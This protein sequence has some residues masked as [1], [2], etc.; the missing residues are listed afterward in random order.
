MTLLGHYSN[1]N[2]MMHFSPQ[3]FSIR[4]LLAMVGGVL[5]SLGYIHV[6]LF[7]G[8]WVAFIPLLIAIKHMSY[9]NSYLLG[10][11]FGMVL[12]LC[13]TTWIVDFLTLFKNYRGL[14][15]FSWSL[16]YWVYCAQLPALMV[17]CYQWLKRNTLV[18]EFILFPISV[19]LF[20]SSFPMLFSAQLGESQS[21]FLVAIQAVEF[22]G[23]YSL[24]AII[25]LV[26]V[27]LFKILFDRGL[28]LKGISVAMT[29][30][31]LV[32]WF[33]YGVYALQTWDQTI[34][35]WR[36][37][38]IGLVQP[39]ET[40]SLKKAEVYPGY[41]RAYPVEMDMTERLRSQGAELVLW[42]E[43]RYKGYID[44]PHVENAFKREVAQLDVDLIFQDMEKQE[45]SKEKS[46][47]YNLAVMLNNEGEEVGRYR[48][49]K[50]VAFGEYVPLVSD[51]P[52][53]RQWVEAFFGNF[54]NEIGKGDGP[55]IFKSGQMNIVPLVCYETMFAEFVANAVPKQPQGSI[56]VG[57]S[58]NGWFGDSVQPYQHIYAA[59]LRAVE[60]RLPMI[61]VLNN[62]P[63]VVVM[64][65]GRF[66]FVSDYHQAGGY[67]VDMPFDENSGGSFFSRFPN[68]FLYAVYGLVMAIVLVSRLKG[69][70][71]NSELINHGFCRNDRVATVALL[72]A[73][74][75]IVISIYPK[76]EAFKVTD[77]SQVWKQPSDSYEQYPKSIQP[78]AWRVDF[79]RIEK[80]LAQA[81]LMDDGALALTTETA[82]FLERLTLQYPNKPTEETR[83]RIQFLIAKTL[84]A[85]ASEQVMDLSH[86][87]S[88]FHAANTLMLKE[89]LDKPLTSAD[90]AEQRFMKSVRLK[91]QY[92][93]REVTEKLY[94]AQHDMALKMFALQREMS[95]NK[96][97]KND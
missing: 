82:Q 46:K 60:N 57:L 67:L 52:F 13:A 28:A 41:G 48:K 15:N 8:A 16:L 50:R 5:L 18:S 7:W 77:Q 78:N 25:A 27:V 74:S 70:R 64:P 44:I 6:D 79:E 68:L 80:I 66:L 31:I 97:S 22:F 58:S 96:L 81:P 43:A 2:K 14:T 75:L 42:P 17:L 62:G 47:R 92:L 34:S 9:R 90:D 69:V 45:E 53:L 21:G 24:D 30:A 73:V 11:A 32:A 55:V 12:F 26:N 91:E 61:H 37:V 10:F 33:G 94:S 65:N 1:K 71:Q 19:V 39:N 29:A 4:L 3:W 51:I 38:R 72:F 63:S 40:P 49:M 35:Q 84:P 85:Q 23:V 59:S 83:K 89:L 87:Y 88:Q 56:L 54:L 20:F 86:R 76:G 95:S 93:G 36:T